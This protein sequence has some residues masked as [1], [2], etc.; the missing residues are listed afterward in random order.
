MKE[1]L[2]SSLRGLYQQT[3]KAVG[4]L[5]KINSSMMLINVKNREFNSAF[6]ERGTTALHTTRPKKKK[7]QIR[8][9]RP[10]EP[11]V[12]SLARTRQRTDCRGCRIP[13]CRLQT[14]S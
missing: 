9:T 14:R 13:S 4:H 3:G 10:R 8:A 1:I 11:F 7:K 5:K 2:L 6:T 12:L